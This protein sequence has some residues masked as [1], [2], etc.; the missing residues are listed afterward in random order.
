MDNASSDNTTVR[1]NAIPGT[2]K[3]GIAVFGLSSSD[4]SGIWKEASKQ[5][6]SWEDVKK[7]PNT[8]SYSRR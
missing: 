2:S 8:I 1:A 7:G 3:F 4:Y 5:S 6:T